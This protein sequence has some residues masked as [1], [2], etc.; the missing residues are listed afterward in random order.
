MPPWRESLSWR[1]LSSA[2]RTAA[3]ALDHG[4]SRLRR[5]GEV[6]G[7][8]AYNPDLYIIRE[9]GG[10]NYEK[11]FLYLFF[12]KDRALPELSHAHLVELNEAMK[13]MNGHPVRFALR[14]FTVWP[15]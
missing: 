7:S 15:K 14:D 3:T 5:S 11:P 9:S 8:R 12:G 1:W 4:W 6:A 2:T 13:S 10:A